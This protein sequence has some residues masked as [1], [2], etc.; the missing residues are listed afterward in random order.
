M[1]LHILCETE[2]ASVRVCKKGVL[3][4]S[5]NSSKGKIYH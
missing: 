2:N 5:V 4:V 1:I 3:A